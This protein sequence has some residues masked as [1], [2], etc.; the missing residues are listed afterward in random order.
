MGSIPGSGRSPGGGNGNPLQYFCLKNSMDME[1]SGLQSVGLQ[2]S[3]T[4]DQ[5]IQGLTGRWEANRRKHSLGFSLLGHRMSLQGLVSEPL[6]ASFPLPV[7]SGCGLPPR[8]TSEPRPRLHLGFSA[9]FG[10]R[11]DPVPPKLLP[12]LL[13]R[14]GPCL[15]QCP[16]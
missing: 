4:R 3:Q 16:Q 10:G 2:K 11:E 14:S 12:G 13:G 5:T 7:L 1:P 6:A 15:L 8:W 9:E